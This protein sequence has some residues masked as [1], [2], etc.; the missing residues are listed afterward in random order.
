MCKWLLEEV[1][2]LEVLSFV[3][4]LPLEPNQVTRLFSKIELKLE[5]S[6]VQIYFES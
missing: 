4:T 3:E 6:L 1:L 2:G 5:G